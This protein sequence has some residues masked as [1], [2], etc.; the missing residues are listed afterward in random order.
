MAENWR[1][2][3]IAGP[4]DQP[5]FPGN[6][7]QV[8]YEDRFGDE[9]LLELGGRAVEQDRRPARGQAARTIRLCC[10]LRCQTERTITI[11]VKAEEDQWCYAGCGATWRFHFE[12][13]VEPAYIAAQKERA[14]PN[15]D[16]IASPAGRRHVGDLVTLD[17]SPATGEE[18]LFEWD[19][20]GDGR[21]D[22]TGGSVSHRLA[23]EGMNLITLT[24]TDRWGQSDS[25]TRGSGPSQT[26][27][28]PSL[29]WA[30]SG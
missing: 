14:L 22:A 19:F 30:C 18:L 5:V 1:F 26:W 15:A 2:F 16:F 11:D 25:I 6:L 28:G 13:L 3:A 27:K 4:L 9:L 21:P 24:V 7:P 29:S 8:I 20:D 10:P 23:R 17:G 12:V